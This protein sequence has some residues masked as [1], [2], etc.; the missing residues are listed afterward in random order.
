ML[1]STCLTMICAEA[2]AEMPRLSTS[3]FDERVYEN[4][5]ISGALV[6]GL[7]RIA[8][9]LT[10]ELRISAEVPEDW[11]DLCLTVTT[12]DGLYESRNRYLLPDGWVGGEVIFDYPTSY[13]DRLLRT[14]TNRIGTLVQRGECGRRSAQIALSGWRLS[15]AAPERI[16]LYINSFQA[17]E[18]FA[19]VGDGPETACDEL[20]EERKAAFDMMCDLILPDDTDSPVELELIRVRSGRVEASSSLSVEW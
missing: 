19:Y 10:E 14:D 11:T 20:T 12:V 1:L 7:S 2:S 16:R 6:V 13:I 15:E 5:E 4:S 17:D 3:P 9:S 8:G 18:V